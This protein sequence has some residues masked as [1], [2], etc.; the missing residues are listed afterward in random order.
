M[1]FAN[2]EDPQP[3]EPLSGWELAMVR[4]VVLAIADD[5]AFE[6]LLLTALKEAPCPTTALV[7]RNNRDR[8]LRVC[9]DGEPEGIGQESVISVASSF[10]TFVTLLNAN[11]ILPAGN[12]LDWA[13]LANKVLRHRVNQLAAAAGLAL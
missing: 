8:F 2:G 10:S 9:G 7:M 13:N 1:K 6:D 12:G 5:D 3:P 4:M 11:G